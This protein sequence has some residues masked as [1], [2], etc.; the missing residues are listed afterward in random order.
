M[1]RTGTPRLPIV[2]SQFSIFNFPLSILNSQFNEGARHQEHRQLVSRQ[3]RRRA[4]RRM[5]NQRE[6]P[7]EGYPQHQPGSCGRLRANHSQP[8]RYRLHQRNRRPQEL[9]HPTGVQPVEAVAHHRCQPRPVHAH[10]HRQLSRNVDHLHR[11]LP[12]LGRS[13]PHPREAHLQQDRCLR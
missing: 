10:R 3:D 7:P 6:L 8:G 13:L 4:V 11:P 9:H 1:T 2:N 5:Q 12:R